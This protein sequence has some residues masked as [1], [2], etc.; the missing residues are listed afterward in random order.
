M[1]T[2]MIDYIHLLLES[3]GEDGGHVASYIPELAQA[4]PD[5]LAVAIATLD[6]KVYVAGDADVEFTI[7]SISK[8]LTYALAIADQGLESVLQHIDV[9]PSGDAFN[10][11]SL[12]PDT[13]RPRNPM[14]NAGAIAA[15]ALVSGED[16]D[17]RVDRIVDLYS[18][19]A[20]RSLSIA[21]DVF[22]SELSEADRNMALAYMLRTVG[23]LEGTPTDV[24]RG[25]TRQCSVSVTVR[26]LARMASVLA[27]GG[28]TAEGER[29]LE[30]EVNRQV[31]S[32]MATC[33]MYNSA[34]DWLTS[35]GIP[36]KSGVAGGLMGIMPGQVGI[37]V[38]SPRL[39]AHGNSTRGVRMFERMNHDLGL[40][41]MNASASV[42]TVSR[43][44]E[45]DGCSVH[46]ITGDLHFIEAERIMRG[47]EDEPVGDAPVVIDLSQ[48]RRANDIA[49][50]VMLEGIRRLHLDG[51]EIRLVDP[52]GVLGSAETGNGELVRG[53]Q[54][55][56]GYVPGAFANVASAVR[57]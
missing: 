29:V 11:I 40:H 19:L 20:G 56:G 28:V 8:P 3:I 41:L 47:F 10:E 4:N 49:R 44:V 15:H 1:Q 26:D 53:E 5:R 9:E 39:D 46:E 57:G 45:I 33:G 52:W 55:R 51:H 27:A 42:S 25:Y 16:A 23:K 38:F 12:D 48:V 13:G 7:Q 21:E 54:A 43:R 2:P 14:I 36:A 50:R 22:E 35:V 30:P 37:A 34:G 31:L 6:G 32:V 17:A 24:V 18:R